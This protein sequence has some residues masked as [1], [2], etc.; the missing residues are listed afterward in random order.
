MR[1]DGCD[2]VRVCVYV[3]VYVFWVWRGKGRVTT[4]ARKQSPIYSYCLCE[5]GSGISLSLADSLVK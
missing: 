4:F 3:Y 1:G 2:A 5:I